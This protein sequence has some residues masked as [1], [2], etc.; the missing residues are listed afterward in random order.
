MLSQGEDILMNKS[1]AV[2]YFK[3]SA[4][5][6]NASAQCHYGFMLARGEG[7]SMT[8]SLAVHYSK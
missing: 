3:L 1:L 8:E 5:Q 2:H 7:I 4:D 6:G